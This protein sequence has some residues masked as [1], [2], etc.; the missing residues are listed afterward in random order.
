MPN[1]NALIKYISSAYMVFL[2]NVNKGIDLKR[3][4]VPSNRLRIQQNWTNIINGSRAKVISSRGMGD[5]QLVI[6]RR[7]MDHR[8]RTSSKW[9]TLYVFQT[10]SSFHLRRRIYRQPTNL[11]GDQCDDWEYGIW[12]TLITAGF[13]VGLITRLV[14]LLVLIHVHPSPGVDYLSYMVQLQTLQ[15]IATQL[16]NKSC[17]TIGYK[18]CDNVMSL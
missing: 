17:D 14:G 11:V 8:K 2:E 4:R 16:A 3:F 7:C 5:Y 18:V 9:V 1:E 12:T 15:P 10:L 6:V 13:I